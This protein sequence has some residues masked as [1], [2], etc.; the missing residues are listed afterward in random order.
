MVDYVLIYA[1]LTTI[2]TIVL[3]YV[4]YRKKEIIDLGMELVIAYAD[5]TVTEEEYG[6]IVERLKA[7]LNK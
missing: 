2:S 1:I 7:V 4:N 3:G 5:Q 6:K